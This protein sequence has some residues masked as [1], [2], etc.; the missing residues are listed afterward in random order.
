MVLFISNKKFIN[1]Q[2]QDLLLPSLLSKLFRAI[3]VYF[4]QFLF[5]YNNENFCQYRN[6]NLF[7]IIL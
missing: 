3:I 2:K 1:L 6:D 4:Y 5:I 7:K